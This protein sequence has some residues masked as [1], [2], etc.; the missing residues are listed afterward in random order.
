MPKI[1]KKSFASIMSAILEGTKRA[2]HHDN[3]PFV[4]VT[5]PEKSAYYLGQFMQIKMIEIIYLG[6]LLNV[7][8]FD[9]PQ[10]E[11]YKKETKNILAATP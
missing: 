6:F 4:S 9:Q 7:N 3:R 1:Q 10:V 11:S 5:L 8:P 2:Y